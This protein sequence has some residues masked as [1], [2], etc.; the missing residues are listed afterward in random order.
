M[1]E[2]AGNAALEEV[3]MAMEISYGVK[4]NLN[5]HYINEISQYT[6]KASKSDIAA[7][8]PIVGERAFLH[9]S[10][11]HT[12]SMIKDRRTYQILSAETIGRTESSF[13]FGKHS[14]AASLISFLNDRMIDIDLNQASIILKEIKKISIE[15]KR[16]LSEKELLNIYHKSVSN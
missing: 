16:A 2:R 15:N 6:S 1:G 4:M 11:I 14:G 9:E 8:K 13:V 10:G 3:C 5:Y 12:R 7:D